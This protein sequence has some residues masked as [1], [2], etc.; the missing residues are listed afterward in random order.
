MIAADS[1]I[2]HAV[3]CQKELAAIV[4]EAI[5]RLPSIYRLAIILHYSEG[6]TLPELAE[7][8]G[9]PVGTVK[10]HLFRGRAMLKT[11]L[12]KKF[13]IEDLVE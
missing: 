8:L 11:D 10:S 9:M 7:S 6:L 1:P 13:T 3:I 4:T 12:L 2:P 5:E